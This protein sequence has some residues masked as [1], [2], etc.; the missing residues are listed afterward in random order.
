MDD[1]PSWLAGAFFGA[2]FA[3]IAMG[4]LRRGNSRVGG[5][6]TGSG[7]AEMIERQRHSALSG[8]PLHGDPD[9]MTHPEI[10][11]AIDGR[12]KILAIK[13]AREAY[14]LSLKEAKELVER[15]APR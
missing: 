7:Q 2:V 1:I 11:A 6:S 12:Q 15:A 14:G 9:I 5:P 13:L 10:R 8:G 3:V 4:I